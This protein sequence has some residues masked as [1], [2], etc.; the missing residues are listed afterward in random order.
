[1]LTQCSRLHSQSGCKMTSATGPLKLIDC[2]TRYIVDYIGEARPLDYVAL[3][4]L[5]GSEA[6][7]VEQKGLESSQSTS[8]LSEDVPKT[9]EDAITVTKS[10]GYKYLWVDKH[11]IDQSKPQERDSEIRRM[12]VIYRDADVTIIDATGK[13]PYGGL[14]G[15]RPSSRSPH[16]PSVRLRTFELLSAMRRP[17]W[18]IMNSWWST[19]GWTFQEGLLSSRRL[20]FTSQQVYFHCRSRYCKE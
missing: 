2:N 14:S 20:V 15:V 18:D 13:D 3:S 9:I 17:E 7:G 10:L 12:D 8:K 1:W 16:Q 5:W 11:C 19:R 6:N 4:Y